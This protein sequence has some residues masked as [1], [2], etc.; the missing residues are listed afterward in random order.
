MTVF[1]KTNRLARKSI[2]AYTWKYT[3]EHEDAYGNK[4]KEV[5]LTQR[6]SV[7]MASNLDSGIFAGTKV[8]KV[9]YVFLAN[10]SVFPNMVIYLLLRGTE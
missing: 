2:I 5:R 9:N 6:R 10:R 7:G 3:F 1:R 4:E 8:I